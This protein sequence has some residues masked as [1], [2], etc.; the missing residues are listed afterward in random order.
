M[1]NNAYH[2]KIICCCTC[3]VKLSQ[4]AENKIWINKWLNA[5]C[6]N[7]S[8]NMQIGKPLFLWAFG[9]EIKLY[10]TIC[11]PDYKALAKKALHNFPKLHDPIFARSVFQFVRSFFQ[12]CWKTSLGHWGH[13]FTVVQENN[14]F[15]DVSRCVLHAFMST[16]IYVSCSGMSH[17]FWIS[18]IYCLKI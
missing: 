8:E 7:L 11:N 15:S 2:C 6:I 10:K 13:P 16:I 9:N 4:S 12:T 3:S 18:N 17:K 5:Y 14:K 1:K